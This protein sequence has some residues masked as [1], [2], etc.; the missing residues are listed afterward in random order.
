MEPPGSGLCQ[1]GRRAPRPPGMREE[2]VEEGKSF[3]LDRLTLS[4]FTPCWGSLPEVPMAL[5]W[6]WHRRWGPQPIG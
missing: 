4:L 3:C 1:A 2:G 6:P 5:G